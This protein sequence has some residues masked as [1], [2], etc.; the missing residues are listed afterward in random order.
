MLSY[1]ELLELAREM[2]SHL[3]SMQTYAPN[4]DEYIRVGLLVDR[5]DREFSQQSLEADGVN[6]D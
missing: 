2:R 5:F 4:R 6:H 3:K 1:L